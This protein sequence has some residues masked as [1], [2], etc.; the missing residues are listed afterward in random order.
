MVEWHWQEDVRPVPVSLCGLRISHS[1]ARNRSRAFSV[2][3]PTADC[4]RNN[5]ASEEQTYVLM[6]HECSS[7]LTENTHIY[8][9]NASWLVV[10]VCVRS[11]SRMK[12]ITC[13]VRAK[14]RD[15][16]VT[17]RGTYSYHWALNFRKPSSWI[18]VKFIQ[19]EC[20]P[21][22]SSCLTCTL[23]D[24]WAAVVQQGQA[25]CAGMESALCW[26]CLQ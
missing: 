3:G 11:H 6:R 10:L 14:C 20:Q 22:P 16:S 7:Y 25:L 13:T 9:I 21:A 26:P 8:I 23:S 15:F 19:R 5:T 17:G 1:F 4:L 24:M 18:N 12:H 2:K